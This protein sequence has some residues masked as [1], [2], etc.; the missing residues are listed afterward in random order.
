MNYNSDHISQNL[1]HRNKY[2]LG[3]VENKN[4]FNLKYIYY[5]L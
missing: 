1:T 4:I 5:I 2:Y 3:T